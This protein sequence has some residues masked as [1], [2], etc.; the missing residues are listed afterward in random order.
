MGD[1]SI[2][3]R[4]SGASDRPLAG[5]ESVPVIA[6][7]KPAGRF[8]M[9]DGHRLGG[10]PAIHKHLIEHGYIDGSTP[11]ITGK[12]LAEN[13]AAAPTLT[14][15]QEV[16]R[17]SAPFIRDRGHIHVLHGNLA[18]GGAFLSKVF[19]GGT[20]NELLAGLKR[21]YQ[22][23]HHIKPPASRKESPELYV[24]AKGFRGRRGGD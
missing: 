6:D 23:V 18:P 24:L 17:V 7:M 16:L 1:G 2:L 15:E 20:E 21:D 4:E 5:A 19:R 9:A 8:V 22:S 14:D 10:T 13:V 3:P 11:T 12:S